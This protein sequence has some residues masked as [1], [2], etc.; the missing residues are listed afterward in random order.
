M[1]LRIPS[2]NKGGNMQFVLLFKTILYFSIPLM[3]LSYI[4]NRIKN[5]KVVLLI[6]GISVVVTLICG[7]SLFIS[8][9]IK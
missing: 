2:R 1:V 4:I 6:W 7:L 9:L 5:I 8:S 3:L